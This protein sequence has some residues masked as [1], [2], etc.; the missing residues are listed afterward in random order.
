MNNSELLDRERYQQALL[1]LSIKCTMPMGTVAWGEPTQE[2][3]LRMQDNQ[4]SQL[5]VRLSLTVLLSATEQ[6]PRREKWRGGPFFHD[7]YSQGYSPEPYFRIALS[8][9]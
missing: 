1:S 7:V 3:T 8:W 9:P 4:M 6:K 5:S 2:T